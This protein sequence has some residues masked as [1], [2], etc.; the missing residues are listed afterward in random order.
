V[1]DQFY[2]KGEMQI[3]LEISTFYVNIDIVKNFLIFLK[4]FQKKDEF[5][6]LGI[7]YI[8]CRKSNTAISS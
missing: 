4:Y 8:I 6:N 5:L 1:H 3:L 7:V 2:F